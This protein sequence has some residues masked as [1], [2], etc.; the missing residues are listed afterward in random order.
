MLHYLFAKFQTENRKWR[1]ILRF[2]TDFSYLLK[3]LKMAYKFEVRKRV[4]YNSKWLPILR[5]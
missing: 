1:S 3:K 4:F 2:L 5:L